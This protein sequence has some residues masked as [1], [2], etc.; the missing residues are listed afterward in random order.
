MTSNRLSQIRVLLVDDEMQILRLVR[1]VLM[2]LGFQD[3]TLA[4]DG[5]EGIAFAKTQRFDFIITDWR[6]PDIEGI[7]LIRFVRS[8]PESLSPRVPIIMLSGNTEA[9]YVL[10]ARDAGVNEY[11]IKPFTAEQLVRRLRAIIEKPRSFVEAPKYRG[12]N[13]RWHEVDNAFPLE[14]RKNRDKEKK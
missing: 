14:R 1:D 6:M 2:E 7:E 10:Q 4:H 8:S 13:R 11:V 12:P 9:T 3:I 5:R